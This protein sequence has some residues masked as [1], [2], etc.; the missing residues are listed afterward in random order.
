[1]QSGAVFMPHLENWKTWGDSSFFPVFLDKEKTYRVCIKDAYNMSYL[2]HFRS[3]LCER[4]NS[5]P[6]N[7]VN[8][9]GVK[10]LTMEKTD[11]P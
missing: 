6:N 1:M 2:Q 7:R 5:S 11:V 4:G 9:A 10:F 8:L 3:Y